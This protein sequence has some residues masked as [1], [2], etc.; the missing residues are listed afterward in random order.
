MIAYLAFYLENFSIADIIQKLFNVEDK[1]I[2]QILSWLP[3]IKK[4]GILR[5][6]VGINL[7]G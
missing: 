4:L 2:L 3:V 1:N 5:A 6:G 7:T